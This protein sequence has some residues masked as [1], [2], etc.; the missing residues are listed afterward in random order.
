MK[1]KKTIIMFF[2]ISMLI[3][4]TSCAYTNDEG[5]ITKNTI[6]ENTLEESSFPEF[7]SIENESILE[8]LNCDYIVPMSYCHPLEWET[9]SDIYP[10]NFIVFY[11]VKARPEPES[12]TEDGLPNYP[13]EEEESF[14]KQYFDVDTDT[15]RSA[16][17][18]DAELGVYHTWGIGNVWESRVVGASESDDYLEIEYE[19]FAELYSGITNVTHGYGSVLL[20]QNPDNTNEYK[21]ISNEYHKLPLPESTVIGES[22]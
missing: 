5:T 14:I 20:Q 10:D 7:S 11:L 9:A 18:Y 15:L 17:M 4:S 6:E 21:F 1:F 16:Q 13:Q 22:Y 2:V 12:K 8:Q 3:S 19:I